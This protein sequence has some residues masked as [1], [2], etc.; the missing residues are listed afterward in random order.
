MTP[1]LPHAPILGAGFD[2]RGLRIPRGGDG[3][4]YTLIYR[5]VP[6]GAVFNG[7]HRTEIEWGPG[8]GAAK[9]AMAALVA[10]IPAPDI[11]GVTL[12]VDPEMVAEELAAIGRVRGF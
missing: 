1:F 7:F 5:G 2:L 6:V 10:A 4:E 12:E 11:G 8:A 3:F 9:A